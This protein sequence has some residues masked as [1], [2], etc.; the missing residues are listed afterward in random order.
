M[1]RGNG[2]HGV[3]ALAGRRR[4][5]VEGHGGQ[6][7]FAVRVVGLHKDVAKR[8][9]VLLAKITLKIRVLRHCLR[10]LCKH[11]TKICVA[12]EDDNGGFC[13]SPTQVGKQ[14][15]DCVTERFFASPEFALGNKNI[16]AFNTDKDVSLSLKI[17]CLAG[18][19]A[20]KG[21]IELYKE[22]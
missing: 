3:V 2:H 19:L 8:A 10:Y 13:V 16:L 9:L 14:L 11:G 22:M 15:V 17:K 7:D 12:V 21:A 18:R 4:R 5:N 6:R 1:C 20:L